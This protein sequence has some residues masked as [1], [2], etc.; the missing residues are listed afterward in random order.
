MINT[1]TLSSTEQDPN[2]KETGL[3]RL[4]TSE[5]PT[6]TVT[7]RDLGEMIMTQKPSEQQPPENSQAL[8]WSIENIGVSATV[9]RS[10][11]LNALRLPQ[12]YGEALTVK[13]QITRVPVRKPSK[14]DFFRSHPDSTWQLPI[15]VLEL[16]EEREI[17]LLSPDVWDLLPELQRTVLLVTAVDRRGNAFLIPIPLP[18]PDGRR[19]SWH[20]SLAAVVKAAEKNWVRIIANMNI[21]GYDM[22]VAEADLGEPVW[23]DISFDELVEIAFRGKIID[24][25][26]HPVLQ[27][28]MGAI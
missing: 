15:M 28:L 20:D 11:D 23:P 27:Q 21:G 2:E 22:L 25:P 19:N 14:A 16:P 13:R 6:K 1:V 26:S 5:S 12:N 18:G 3:V 17:Y 4:Q 9:K 8:G 10:F 24:S 7:K